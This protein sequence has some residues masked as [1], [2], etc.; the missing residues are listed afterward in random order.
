MAAGRAHRGQKGD[1]HQSL[2]EK[3][4]GLGKQSRDHKVERARHSLDQ[5]Y[6][7]EGTGTS[8]SLRLE[9]QF[10]QTESWSWNHDQQGVERVHHSSNRGGA[11]AKGEGGLAEIRQERCVPSV[12]SS[13]NFLV[14]Q[15]L[16]CECG[17]GQKRKRFSQKR[18]QTGQ[19]DSDAGGKQYHSVYSIHQSHDV[20]WVWSNAF[21]GKGLENQR[22]SQSEFVRHESTSDS[23][24]HSSCWYV[25]SE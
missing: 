17:W 23:K 1:R 5:K 21:P 13:D 3:Y 20:Q 6:W 11:C 19:T 4:R 24:G 16:K 12:A 15:Q 9:K 2:D 22:H 7:H 8:A 25:V 14:P 18:R 10:D